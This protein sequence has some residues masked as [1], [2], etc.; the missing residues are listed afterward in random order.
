MKKFKIYCKTVNFWQFSTIALI[1]TGY[2][3]PETDTFNFFK[4]I[5]SNADLNISKLCIYT[6]S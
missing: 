4:A 1:S 6:I 5:S 3:F 2:C